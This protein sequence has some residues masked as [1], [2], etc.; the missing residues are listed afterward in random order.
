MTKLLSVKYMGRKKK[1][2]YPLKK[3]IPVGKKTEV[4]GGLGMTCM[5]N[6]E[7]KGSPLSKL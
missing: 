7:Q 2:K 1:W 4:H 5:K 3:T 6:T